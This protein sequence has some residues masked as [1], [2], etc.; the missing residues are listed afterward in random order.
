M[1][2]NDPCLQVFTL[3]VISYYIAL[4]LV[5]LTSRIET[6]EIV[7]SFSLASLLRFSNHSSLGD[8][9]AFSGTVFRERLMWGAGA[10]CQQPFRALEACPPPKTRLSVSSVQSLSCVQLFATLWTA[11]CQASLSITNSWSLLKLM[12]IESVMPFKHLILC[13]PLL[14]P[15]SVFPSIKVFSNESVLHMRWPK[16][17]SFSCNISP[18]NEYSRPIS[19]RMNWLDLLAVQ[20]TLK[21]LLQHHTLKASILWYSAFF[22][23]QLSHPYLT[24]GKTKALTRWIVVGKDRPV[25]D[26]ILGLYLDCNCLRDPES[27]IPN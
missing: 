15:P 27:Q 23:V 10:S 5:C 13:L 7:C 11:A 16:Y 17:W 26:Y 3:S 24:T 22:I 14:L 18:S 1:V 6:K 2:P 8:P 9:G 12:S 4:E 20:E 19:F 25:G 21:S